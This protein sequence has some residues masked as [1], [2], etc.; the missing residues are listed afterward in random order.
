MEDTINLR[1]LLQTLRKRLALIISIILIAAI[2]S[3]VISYFYLTPIYQSSTQILVNE[4]KNNQGLANS[5]ETVANQTVMNT[6]NVIIKSPAILDLVSKELE[7]PISAGMISVDSEN[8]SQVVR[9]SVTD[10]DPIRAAKTANTTAEVFQEEIVKIMNI[11]N[12]SI[13]AKADESGSFYPIAPNPERNI[14]IA[15][16]IGLVIGIGLALLLDYFDNTI[17]NEHDIERILKIP[18]LGVVSTMDE[19]IKGKFNRNA[20]QKEH[21]KGESKGA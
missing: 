18:V 6:Y 9:I 17:K 7:M 13:L 11:D 2:I 3:G 19:P 15:I 16:V 5:G 20:K 14:A 21:V 12:V 10:T 1:E 8:G 4:S